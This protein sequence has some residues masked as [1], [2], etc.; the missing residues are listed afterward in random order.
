MTS[1]LIIYF[2][3]HLSSILSA[4]FYVLYDIKYNVV[5]FIVTKGPVTDAQS[6]DFSWNKC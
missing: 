4:T 1:R 6:L 5:S 2:T 3:S